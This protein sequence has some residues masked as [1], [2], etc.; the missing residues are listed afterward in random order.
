MSRRLDGGSQRAEVPALPAPERVFGRRLD[1]GSQR[2][3]V[4]ALPAPERSMSR[5]HLAW[6]V[7]VV[8]LTVGALAAHAATETNECNGIRDCI[9]AKGPWVVVPAHGRVAYLL[10]CPRRRGVVG[11]VDALASSTDVHV[12]FDGQLG[13]PVSPGR[14]TTRYAFFR[15]VSASHRRGAFQPRVGCIPTNSSAR[16][17]TSAS[18]AP[19]PPLLLA[20]TTLRLRPG[21]VRTLTIGCIPGQKLVDSWYAI[22]FRTVRVPNVGLADAVRVQRTARGNKIAVSIAT[23]EALPRGTGVEVQLGVMCSPS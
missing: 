13:A 2:A 21:L 4:P 7:L 22:A 15:A 8:A 14:T 19:G 6:V 3:E 12:S 1:G 5:L 10:D 16:S 23:S 17:T 20:A 9:R 18:A 11:G